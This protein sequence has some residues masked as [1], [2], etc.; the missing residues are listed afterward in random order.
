[1]SKLR[2][3]N[4]HEIENVIL[5]RQALEILAAPE[6]EQS[7]L[8]PPERDA[9]E[10]MVRLFEDAWSRT[11]PVF[12]PILTVALRE[13]LVDIERALAEDPPDFERVRPL[14]ER[15]RFSLP[16]VATGGRP[17]PWL[18]QMV[19]ARGGLLLRRQL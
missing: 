9:A 15:A 5:L 8:Y 11:R 16:G 14:A 10:E 2:P 19:H 13:D 12:W 7:S 17:R 4:I 18:E 3:P 6:D 1:M